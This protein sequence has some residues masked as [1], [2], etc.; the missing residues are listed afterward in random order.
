MKSTW[1]QSAARYLTV[2]ALVCWVVMFM[3]GHDVWHD[4]GRPALHVMGA[5][6][7]DL[8]ALAWAFYLLPLCLAGAIIALV[9]TARRP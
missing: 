3:A 2:L 9:V 6:N 4:A 1:S 5:T 8:R 7:F